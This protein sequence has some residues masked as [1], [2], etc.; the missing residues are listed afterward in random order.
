MAR[1][2]LNALAASA[3]HGI[4]YMRNILPRLASYR[5]KHKFTVL[6]P[7]A[8]HNEYGSLTGK[9]LQMATTSFNGNIFARLLWE[10]TVIRNFIKSQEIDILVSLG[11]FGLIRSPVPQ[12][13]SS[14]N[15]LYF[16]ETFE[17]DLKRRKEYS[18]LSVH[19][20]K[21][22]LARLSIKHADINVTPSNAFTEHI[23]SFDD[24]RNCRFEVLNY[25]FDP[26]GFT[27][28]SNPPD[29]SIFEKL[30]TSSN[31]YRLLY[32]SHYN[33]FRNFETLIRALPII[34]DRIAS[35]EGKDVQLVL[36]TD[37]KGGAVYGGYDASSASELIDKMGVRDSIAMLGP[38][39][40]EKVHH[41][42]RL[43]DLSIRPSYCESFGNPLLEAMAMGVANVVADMDV[44]K[45]VCGDSA[46][47]FNTFDKRSLA[48]QCVRLLMDKD[49]RCILVKRGLGRYKQFSWD[50]HVEK[51]V[52]LVDA[53]I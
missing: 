6:V 14:N 17:N 15:D 22:K 10:Q 12:I 46:L 50:V 7:K 4:T 38:I 25:G 44:H 3:G 40:Y 18:K 30:K 34:K 48:R 51:L 36:T 20:L 31:C 24:L 5:G 47:Y 33:Y 16:S 26:R 37:I 43:C 41:L 49:L 23:R 45:E 2:L 32:V 28:N 13:L 8:F 29:R 42:Y 39:P 19:R 52:G 1:V 9:N 11:N 21:C 27:H 53:L 35:E